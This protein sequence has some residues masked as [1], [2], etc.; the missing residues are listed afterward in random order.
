MPDSKLPVLTIAVPTYNR[1]A[2]L[3]L[4]LDYLAPQLE[5]MAAADAS[6]PVELLI[7]DNASPDGTQAMLQQRIAAGL[8]CRYLRS[9]ANIGPDGNFLRCYN[10]AAGRYVWIFGDDDVIF[11]G[12]LARILSVL[13]DGEP[14]LIFVPSLGFTGK[15]E[16]RTRPDPGAQVRL[17][18]TPAAF[19]RA[20]GFV[21]D[22]ALISSVI[23]QREHTESFSHPPYEAGRDSNLIQ[24]G[25]TFTALR[26]MRR[27][28]IFQHGL[29]S[30]SEAAPSRPFD[31]ARVFATHWKQQAARFLDPASQLFR[32]VLDGQMYSWFPAN[33]VGMRRDGYARHTP[34]PVRQVAA[35]YRGRWTFWIFTFPLLALPLPLARAWLLPIRA[36]RFLHRQLL[37]RMHPPAQL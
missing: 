3:S 14:D 16:E 27:A 21:G 6:I 22:L 25:W 1:A 18:R 17:F 5:A 15:P 4:L 10:E 31:V 13:R 29:I 19:L 33:W 32:Q 12:A 36:L 20:L 9:E 26:H 2:E 34:R 37:F 11:P 7:C 35:D 24:L 8:R 30:T 28:A 23:V